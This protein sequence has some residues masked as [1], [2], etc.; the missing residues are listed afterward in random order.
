MTT[1]HVSGWARLVRRVRCALGR[2]RC[3]LLSIPEGI[4]GEC[5]H[6]GR[7]FGWMSAEEL[8][9]LAP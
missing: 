5:I 6:C 2:H 7:I 8:R 3:R 4:G 1:R 9:R